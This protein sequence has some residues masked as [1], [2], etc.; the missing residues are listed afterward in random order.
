MPNNEEKIF[1]NIINNQFV[2]LIV[3]LLYE[4]YMK[5][6][7]KKSIIFINLVSNIYKF[8]EF[9]SIEKQFILSEPLLE[10]FNESKFEDLIKK[11]SR[12][13]RFMNKMLNKTNLVKK[14]EFIY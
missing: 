11:N 9:K 2:Y 1:Y 7:N 8:F 14:I 4:N 6:N 5:M 13:N 10:L 12:I 3:G